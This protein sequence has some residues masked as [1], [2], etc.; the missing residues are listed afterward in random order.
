MTVKNLDKKVM[1]SAFCYII[2]HLYFNSFLKMLETLHIPV[3]T[4]VDKFNI[5]TFSTLYVYIW[6]DKNK[7]IEE[8]G[9]ALGGLIITRWLKFSKSQTKTFSY[10]SS[11]TWAGRAKPFNLANWGASC[12]PVQDFHFQFS[13]S[14]NPLTLHSCSS[15]VGM[16]QICWWN[17]FTNSKDGQSAGGLED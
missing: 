17:F 8:K 4:S 6:R 13:F 2:M 5:E 1:Q 14:F 15:C 16:T 12:S 9:K 3:L 7:Q 11:N 10:C